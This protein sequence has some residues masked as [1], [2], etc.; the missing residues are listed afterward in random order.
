M[1]TTP[2]PNPA[3]PP[4]PIRDVPPPRPTGPAAKP[5]TPEHYQ[6]LAEANLRAKKV[7]KAAGVAMFN[8]CTFG[9][10]AACGLLI[11]LFSAAMGEADVSGLLV[12]SALGVLAWNEFH[13][14]TLLRRFDLRAPA[15]LGWNQIALM[16][17]IIA[18]CGWQ[19]ANALL[20]P[21]EFDRQM[22]AYPEVMSAFGNIGELY[23]VASVAIYGTVILATVLFQ[24]LNALYYFTRAKYLRAYLDE[25]PPWVV[26][27]QRSGAA[28]T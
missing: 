26:E 1:T 23:R 7:L 17:V 3:T 2:Q 27:V 8:A 10:F 4:P 12:S 13:G 14:R 9:F 15:V 21:N 18:Y 24:G 6:A 25:T 22:K 16:A 5:L 20:G 19:I 11:V 28:N